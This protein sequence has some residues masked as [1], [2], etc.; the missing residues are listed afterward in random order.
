MTTPSVRFFFALLN[1]TPAITAPPIRRT[2]TTVT[3]I[4]VRSGPRLL[5]A[6]ATD[7]LPD[8]VL[9]CCRFRRALRSAPPTDQPFLTFAEQPVQ[10]Q[11]GPRTDHE[12]RRQQQEPDV[13]RDLL[14]VLRLPRRDLPAAAEAA[15]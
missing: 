12:P 13:P 9:A 14:R 4:L 5:R 1:S 15:A 10:R 11:R 3:M 8:E 7:L 6:D 2:T